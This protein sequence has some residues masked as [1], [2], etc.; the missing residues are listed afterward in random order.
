[1][2][3]FK[4][5]F[6]E[7]LTIE[8]GNYREHISVEVMIDTVVK[9]SKKAGIPSYLALKHFEFTDEEIEKYFNG[10]CE[11]QMPMTFI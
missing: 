10:L 7:E 5:D 4:K 2:E 9:A 3:S 1:M 11:E 8:L 6:I